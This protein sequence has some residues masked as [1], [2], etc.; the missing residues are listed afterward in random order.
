MA[1]CHSGVP[2]CLSVS[3]WPGGWASTT[4]HIQ[5]ILCPPGLAA[6]FY[7]MI[8]TSTPSFILSPKYSPIHSSTHTAN[9]PYP[10]DLLSKKGRNS[11]PNPLA[12]RLDAC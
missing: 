12:G 6:I 5:Y 7:S 4:P 8:Q 9:H 10:P 11:I 3:G 2:S 1:I